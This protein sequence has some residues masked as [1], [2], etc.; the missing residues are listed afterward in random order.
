MAATKGSSSLLQV[1]G[2]LLFTARGRF[3][4]LAFF[5]L[6]QAYAI[7]VVMSVGIISIASEFNYSDVDTGLVLSSFFIG[8]MIL[9]IPAGTL[10]AW[11]GGRRIFTLGILL[12]SILTAA[13]P[14]FAGSVTGLVGM[15]VVTGL[16]EGVTYPA[17]HALIAQWVP[18]SERSL[19]V[20][21]MWSGAFMG[22]A[23]TLPIAGA[24]CEVGWRWAFYAFALFGVAVSLA[25]WVLTAD[26]PESHTG[27]DP[28]ERE[29]I[30]AHR[31][32][33]DSGT[34]GAGAAGAAAG[35]G[36]GEER[37]ALLVVKEGQVCPPAA[38]SSAAVP[39]LRLLLCPPVLG[40]VA[41]H[42]GHNWAFYLLLTW[43]PK[44]MKTQLGLD[45][46]AS[47]ALA[48][49]PYLA[50]FAGANLGGALGDYLIERKWRV[51][52]VRKAAFVV[53]ELLPAAALIGAGF[54]RD[55]GTAISLLTLSVGVSGLSQ[56]GYAC[57]PLDVAPHLGSVIMG[58]QNT[59]ATVAGIVAPL[60]AG[61]IVEGHGDAQ[62]W[63]KVFFL[64][65]A[66]ALFGVVVYVALADDQLAP[67]LQPGYRGPWACSVG[68]AAGGRGGGS[69]EVG[70]GED[71]EGEGETLK[72]RDIRR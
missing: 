16:T 48:V 38:P 53:G 8:Y 51:V 35:A 3:S 47:T 20:G 6:F 67:S 15:R 33:H 58:M 56:T 40:C 32:E 45:L 59:M 36:G 42:F 26:S 69:G 57:T 60:V 70:E 34:A 49:L 61:E 5:M 12:P 13:T 7:R 18:A 72:I 46:E 25:F 43:L 66:V 23:A 10:S 22:S 65:G 30:L 4:L 41:A 21:V 27:I 63:Q 68:R 71:S 19:L 64:S 39:F 14:Y 1:L 2:L 11:Y 37:E 54:C 62:H 55:A 24:L 29:F 28:Q 9:Q 50:C 17:L 31:V 44:Y 52:H